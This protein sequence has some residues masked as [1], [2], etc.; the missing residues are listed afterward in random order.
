[1]INVMATL[2]KSSDPY[3][4]AA[5]AVS[6]QIALTG[7]KVAIRPLVAQLSEVFPR[8]GSQELSAAV[9]TAVALAGAEMSW[10]AGSAQSLI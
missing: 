4:A 1:M 8:H 10:N 5:A 9:I 6:R 2:L 7:R 3:P